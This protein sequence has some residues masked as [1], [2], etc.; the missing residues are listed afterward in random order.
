MGP[1]PPPEEPLGFSVEEMPVN[2]EPFEV[3][4]C[5]AV[6][7]AGGGRYCSP[8]SGNEA[9]L[10]LGSAPGPSPLPEVSSPLASDESATDPTSSCGSS[11]GQSSSDSSTDQPTGPA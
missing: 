3:A 1:H 4:R 10:P 5:A 6:A 8:S 11:A 2:G 9:D 7:A